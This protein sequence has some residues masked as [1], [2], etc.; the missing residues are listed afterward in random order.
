MN[1][2]NIEKGQATD[3]G[4]VWYE[5][6]DDG[7]LVL[8]NINLTDY[9]EISF[10]WKEKNKERSLFIPQDRLRKLLEGNPV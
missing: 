2:L 7:V 9:S 8:V 3:C 6:S 10:T 5:A 4:E 1:H